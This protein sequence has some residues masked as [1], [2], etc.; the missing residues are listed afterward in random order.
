M[1]TRPRTLSK[2][3][4]DREANTK[5]TAKVERKVCKHWKHN[6]I[7]SSV[8]LG[9]E[10]RKILSVINN[11]PITEST[12]NISCNTNS[13]TKGYWFI[14]DVLPTLILK[15][16][17]K[18]RSQSITVLQKVMSDSL[19]KNQHL[20]K[21]FSYT[22]QSKAMYTIKVQKSA[23]KLNHKIQYPLSPRTMTLSKVRLRTD[24]AEKETDGAFRLHY[25]FFIIK[26]PS[27]KTVVDFNQIRERERQLKGAPIS[28]TRGG[29]GWG[30]GGGWVCRVY[31]LRS[32]LAFYCVW[33]RLRL[34]SLRKIHVYLAIQNSPPKGQR[35]EKLAVQRF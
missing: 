31:L 11:W 32:S 34:G 4:Q 33:S 26:D 16:K 15:K 22:L 19:R 28:I 23:K 2:A 10:N 1:Y 21:I 20:D 29:G 13:I 30:G 8:K 24:M 9:Q 27:D 18:V 6:E 3:G 25:R 17:K 12:D 5:I 35:W 14:N 7:K